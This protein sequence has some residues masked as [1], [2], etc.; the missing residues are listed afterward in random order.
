MPKY[1]K[2][3]LVQLVIF[4]TIFAYKHFTEAS[5]I[6][7]ASIS[8]NS[9]NF[10]TQ[11]TSI[12]AITFSPDGTKMYLGAF[13]GSLIYQYTLSTAWDITTASYDNKSYNASA[14]GS[15]GANGLTDMRISDDG[16]RLFLLQFYNN[17]I[18]QYN[19][20]TPF[21]ISTTSYANKSY[22]FSNAEFGGDLYVGRPYSMTVTSDGTKIYVLSDY[23]FKVYQVTLTTPWDL[24]TAD[25][26]TKNYTVPNLADGNIYAS[27]ISS[28]GTD[29]YILTY[30]SDRI[31]WFPFG[32]A[33]D[34]STLSYTTGKYLSMNATDSLVSSIV[35]GNN[36][37][38]MFAVGRTNRRVYEINMSDLTA[39]TISSISSTTA[40]GTYKVGDSIVINVTFSEAVTSTGD[41]TITL[42]TG[43]VDRTCTFSISNSTT[44]SCTYTVQTGDTSSD[45][46][47]T[48]SGTIKDASLN[49]LTN[50][51]PTTSLATNKNISIDTTT[52]TISS[53]DS[54][55]IT[56]N[57]ASIS[58]TSS[59]NS[60]SKVYFGLSEYFERE[61]SELNIS[62][63]VSSHSVSLTSLSPCSIYYY[64]AASKDAGLNEIVSTNKSFKTSGCDI[65]SVL[66]GSSEYISLAGGTLIFTNTNSE[67]KLVIPASYSSNR[68][69]FQINKLDSSSDFSK[70]TNKFLIDKNIYKL[71]AVDI[72]NNNVTSFNS[73]L[74]FEITYPETITNDYDEDSL[75]IYKFNGTNW[76][77]KN[78]TLNKN[79]NKVSCNLNSFSIYGLF[80][81][82]IEGGG[83]GED[84]GKIVF[85]KDKRCHALVP[86]DITWIKFRNHSEN[87]KSGILIEWTLV[88]A[89]K[90]SILIDDGTGK[91]PW[92]LS[93]IINDGTEFIPNMKS[94]QKIKILPINDCK[95]GNWSKEFS[96]D[97]YPKGFFKNF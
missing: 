56:N 8:G 16:T 90:V 38:K 37:T 19:L 91:F 3:T 44:G 45:L 67:A 27:T 52:P 72:N 18:H 57:S 74:T 9:F 2:I 10:A 24:A 73:T 32:T 66:S 68:A 13:N 20:A 82:E 31:H 26:S 49:T 86:E 23:N 62:P 84:S 50:F 81:S 54:S 40:N 39:P 71:N 46:D 92:Q 33:Y 61:S 22:V 83:G 87:E 35:L 12:D 88:T 79:T 15:A 63:R 89:D 95:V 47:A 4:A 97:N 93:R 59:E 64:Q 78:C 25:Y 36:D 58:W 77:K 7:L 11:N 41:V 55:S 75:D 76:D 5:D 6:T 43:S 34:I 85:T 42:E 70:P 65:L 48:I 94:W 28:D 60:S 14:Q 29:F 96:M 53:L 69:S 30:N 1:L 17:T 80:G 21:D 51:T